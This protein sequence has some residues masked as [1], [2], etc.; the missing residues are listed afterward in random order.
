MMENLNPIKKN[1]S[2]QVPRE[3]LIHT[4]MEGVSDFVFLMEVDG[5][6]LFRYLHMNE[7]AK[8]HHNFGELTW[9]NK[10]I[11][12]LL[13]EP[14]A[15]A[16]NDEYEKVVLTKSAVTYEDKM[17]IN[18]IPFR[19][20]TSLTPLID[21]YGEVTHILGITRDVTELFEK[22]KDLAEINAV[23]RSLMENTS[24]AI[25]IVDA[26]GELIEANS[27]FE[28]LYGYA[29]KEL[30]ASW[31]PFVPEHL[32][33]EAES[34]IY[35][36]LNNEEI[37]SYQTIR[38]HKSGRFIDVSITVAPIQNDEGR[39][40][41]LSSIIRDV[42]SEKKAKMELRASRSRYRSLFKHNP[43]P[44]LT[45]K[46]DGTITKVNKAVLEMTETSDERL[47]NTSILDWVPYAQVDLVQKQLEDS[48][49]DENVMFQ[50]RF[51]VKEEVKIVNVYLVPIHN[52]N[53]KEGLY[54]IL[55]EITEKEHASEAMRQS[56]AKFRLIADH[57]NDLI[58]VLLPDGEI[59]YASP[60]HAKF[61]GFDPTGYS[62]LDMGAILKEEDLK[63]VKLAFQ[64]CQKDFKPFT[65][66]MKLLNKHKQWVWF[67]CLGTPVLDEQGEVSKIVVVS[68]DISEQK[69]YE[70]QLKKFAFY[71]YLTGLPNRRLFEDRVEETIANYKRNQKEFALLYLD[72]DSFKKINDQHGH[73]SGDEFLRMMA[74]RMK[75][76]LR[77][78]DA[79]GRI[80]GDEF[81]ILM[82]N[83]TSKDE[84]RRFANLLLD[85]LKVP[86]S[87]DGKEIVSTFS[88]GVACFP[89]DGETLDD[90]FRSADQALYHGKRSGKDR[91]SLYK[92]I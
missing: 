35:K 15:K 24:D 39:I 83:F 38:K 91:A 10:Y 44:I 27:A 81:A 72:G 56:E 45:L 90:L 23:Y 74:A 33:D 78:G 67:E 68:R 63:K 55:E 17:Y 5:P 66:A 20:H 1:F 46:L 88:I 85:E 82:Q 21:D 54:A 76:R 75:A 9:Q 59:N 53:K 65:V 42:T 47:I 50:T 79:V 7:A 26:K 30:N 13:D 25:L 11:A 48:L 40:I 61:L 29:K 3:Q 32:K 58:S 87:L 73:D 37:S 69:S 16:L 51:S 8:D 12:D 14:S 80:G 57:S 71:D 84:V 28:Q 70:D 34:L 92:D 86:Y 4:L 2:D 60:S 6:R 64:Q 22:K 43:H 36:G 89:Q 62:L 77:K 41:G 18:G 19:G 52:Q 31:F 49:N